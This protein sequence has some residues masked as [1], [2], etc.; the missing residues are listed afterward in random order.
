LAYVSRKYDFFKGLGEEIAP[1]C[2]GSCFVA[3]CCRWIESVCLKL[4]HCSI[5]RDGFDLA[6]DFHVDG[7]GGLGTMGLGDCLECFGSWSVLGIGCHGDR[8]GL[9]AVSFN[10][11]V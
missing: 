7:N 10:E 9:G 8:V 2:F 6:G 3:P 11:E 5:D 1:V 4:E